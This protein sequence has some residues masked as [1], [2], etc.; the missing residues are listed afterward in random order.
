MRPTRFLP[1]TLLATTAT[2]VPALGPGDSLITSTRI[3]AVRADPA[4]AAPGASVTFTSFVAGPGGTVTGADI[5]WSFCPAPKPLTE[6]NVVSNACL[7]SGSLVAAGA[8]PST[9]AKTPTDGCSVFGPD[10]TSSAFRPR[11]PDGTGG[12]Y[13]PL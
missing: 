6:D 4:E 8:G 7:G 12:Y 11:D 10:T 2:C 1:I 5:G 3:L 13:Q 9:V